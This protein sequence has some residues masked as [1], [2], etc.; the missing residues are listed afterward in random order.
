MNFF[1][2]FPI[3]PNMQVPTNMINN[4]MDYLNDIFNKFNEFDNRI[5]KLEQRITRL[6]NESNKDYNYDEPDNSLYMI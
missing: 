1:P 5:K 4:G 6:E 3:I 2:N